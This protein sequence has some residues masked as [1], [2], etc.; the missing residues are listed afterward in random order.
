MTCAPPFDTVCFDCDSTLCAVEGIDELAKCAGIGEEMAQLTRAAMDGS[1]K[2]EEIYERRLA[3]IRPDLAAIEW[4]GRRYIERL[5]E[6][7][8]ETV[9][10]LLRH[11]KSVHIVSGG[12]RQA[13]LPLARRLGIEAENVHAVDLMFDPT[14]AYAGFDGSSP[15]A[16]SGGKAE[17]CGRLIGRGH[18]LALVGDGVTDLEAARAGAFFIGFGGVAVREIVRRSAQLYFLEPTLLPVLEYLLKT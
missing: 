10:L 4:L 15:L 12:I 16:R 3:S 13:L 14:G 5:V 17:I 9:A 6:G 2:L 11:G 8:S 18:S 1:L 7:A